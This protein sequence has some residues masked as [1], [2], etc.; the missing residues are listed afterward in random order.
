MTIAAV[1]FDLD[2]TLVDSLALIR[3]TYYR[4]FQELAIPWGDDDVMKM[5]GLPLAQIAHHFAGEERADYFVT[6]YRNYYTTDH[7]V[8]TRAYP[9]TKE[10]LEHLQRQDYRLGVVTS[11]GRDVALRSL[12][13][14]DLVQYMDV[15]IT[16]QDVVS[17]KPEPG[18]VLK[19]LECLGI[20]PIDAVY[21]GDSPFDLLAGRRAGTKTIGVTWGMATREELGMNEPDLLIEQWSELIDWLDS[22][23]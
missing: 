4:V 6:V 8:Y 16:A 12:E 20:K 14:L 13:Y 21:V 15:V 18:P 5:I 9:G 7:D 17:H 19:A 10:L 2:G 1:L 23:V 11:K 22:G 3:Q